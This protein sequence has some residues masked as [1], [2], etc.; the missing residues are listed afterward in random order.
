M[1]NWGKGVNFLL[2]VWIS[3]CSGTGFFEKTILPSMNYSSTF[4]ENQLTII[5][6]ISKL[7][8]HSYLLIYI[9]ILSPIKYSLHYSHYKVLATGSANSSN[10]QLQNFLFTWKCF[11]ISLLTCPLTYGSF[12]MVINFYHL[13]RFSYFHSFNLVLLWSKKMLC[14]VISILIK[15]I[16]D[17]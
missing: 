1:Y 9:S 7:T 8:L 5:V 14:F 2:W 16:K 17:F 13:W 6:Q 11:L 10:L 15:F 3:K 4:V 12:K